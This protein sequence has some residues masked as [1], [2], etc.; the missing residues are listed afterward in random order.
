MGVQA[1]WAVANKPDIYAVVLGAPG[2]EIAVATNFVTLYFKT[3]KRLTDAY[4]LFNTAPTGASFIAIVKD[5]GS[6]A[7]TVTV[8]AG[9]TT[10]GTA[11]IPAPDIAANSI[12]TVEIN[13]TGVSPNTGI[14]GVL[15]LV[16]A[17]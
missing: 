12:I 10:S 9:Q 1:S 4:I 17:A 7:A 15:M 2:A 11:S 13:Q 16:F 5:D 14:D 3:A 6:E 8:A